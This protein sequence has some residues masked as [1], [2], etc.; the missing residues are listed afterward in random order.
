MTQWYAL[1]VWDELKAERA[2]RKVGVV[3]YVPCET[4][5]R[6]RGN[7]PKV[8]LARPLIPGYLFAWCDPEAV[9]VEAI[10][11]VHDFVRY[12]RQDGVRLPLRLGQNALVPI[13]LAEV[14]GALDYTKIPPQYQPRRGDQVKIKSGKWR[15][16]FA[17]ILSVGKRRALI[18]TQWCKIEVDAQHLEAAA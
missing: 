14:F 13:I 15:G 17:R 3:A 1:S 18:E 11:E 6:R 12:T 2:L 4:V 8:K 9:D 5:E 7:K 16:Y 10:A